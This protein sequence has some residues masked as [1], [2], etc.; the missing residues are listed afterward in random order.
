MNIDIYS[1]NSNK[2]KFLS[3]ISGT[4]ISNIKINDKDF[5]F[6]KKMDIRLNDC[7]IALNHQDITNQLKQY[8]YA[9]HGVKTN[10]SIV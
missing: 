4:D 2:S 9:L 3:V 8:G 10:F 5:T 7:R 1:S 6:K